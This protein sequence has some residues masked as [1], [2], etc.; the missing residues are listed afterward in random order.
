LFDAAQVRLCG[1]DILR[2]REQECHVD[3]QTGED[4]LLDGGEAILGPRYLDEEIGPRRPGVKS[5]DRSDD[6]GRVV[7]LWQPFNRMLL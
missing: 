6:T 2:T 7:V 4:R 3:R 1:R 5:L